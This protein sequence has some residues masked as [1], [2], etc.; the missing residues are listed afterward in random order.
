[1]SRMESHKITTFNSSVWRGQEYLYQ[2]SLQSRWLVHFTPYRRRHGR[3]SMKGIFCFK[4]HHQYLHHISWQSLQWAPGYLI[5]NKISEPHGSE[6]GKVS[7][8]SSWEHDWYISLPYISGEF[9][10][11]S[12]HPD[13]HMD[14][15]VINTSIEILLE[16]NFS[17]TGARRRFDFFIQQVLGFIVRFSFPFLQVCLTLWDLLCW[18]PTCM[19]FSWISGFITRYGVW[20]QIH[21]HLQ[22]DHKTDR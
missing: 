19:V 5:K 18:E 12:V 4:I 15:Y 21:Q 16:V 17:F 22:I 9:Y 13:V 3:S 1:M 2:T 8:S 20:L 6:R 10:F 11:H 14:P 7:D